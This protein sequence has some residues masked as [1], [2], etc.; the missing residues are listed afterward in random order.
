M[1]ETIAEYI[2][3]VTQDGRDVMFDFLRATMLIRCK[4]CAHW[5]SE[6]DKK[7]YCNGFNLMYRQFESDYYCATA[8]RKQ[9]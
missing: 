1:K 4:D 5:D 6:D 2:V 9:E 7:G 8:E 3:P